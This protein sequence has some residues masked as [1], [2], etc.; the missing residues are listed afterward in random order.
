MIADRAEASF[1]AAFLRNRNVDLGSADDGAIAVAGGYALYARGTYNQVAL[2]IGSTRPLD[3]GDLAAL[4]AFYERRGA[5]VRLELRETALERDHALFEQAGYDV[6]EIRFGFFE[7]AAVPAEPPATVA[8][9]P[10]RHRADWLRVVTRAVAE[11]GRPDEEH[12][13][14]AEVAAAAA[15]GLF[16]AE[17][18]GVA[19][20]AGAV[21]IAG[22]VAYL[23]SGAVLP[24]FRGRGVHRAL[25]RARAEFGAS[26]G[27]AR[28][29]LKAVEG[30]AA[31]RSV[32]RAGFE[33]TAVLRRVR[34]G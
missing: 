4:E 23:Y 2:A 31:E 7:T 12:L 22:E 28:T 25:L 21:G 24:Q 16:I 17:L 33:R 5:P 26:R 9:R 29:A 11:G 30:S 13:R 18:D 34:R 32:R 14:S 19:A 10:A 8:V 15:T 3:A 6:A 20:G 1:W 27:A